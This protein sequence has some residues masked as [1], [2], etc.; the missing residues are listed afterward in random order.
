[1]K[2]DAV[3]MIDKRYIDH[4]KIHIKYARSG[5]Y[6]S[7]H[8]IM[9]YV[10]WL[11]RIAAGQKKGTRDQKLSHAGPRTIQVWLVLLSL[12][13]QTMNTVKKTGAA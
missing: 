2:Y 5:I 7:H 11:I 13:W 3:S 10:I 12:P 8:I 6:V 4:L 1:M 9:C